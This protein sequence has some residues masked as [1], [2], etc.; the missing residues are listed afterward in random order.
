MGSVNRAIVFAS[1][2]HV[3]VWLVVPAQASAAPAAQDKATAQALFEEAR[4]LVTAGK[5]AEA[6]PK[7][8]E[9]DRL[10]PSQ[11]TVFRL[12]ECWERVGKFASA[13]ASYLEAAARAKASG[14]AARESFARGRADAVRD[15]LSFLVVEVEPQD[16]VVQVT[17]DGARVGAAQLGAQV[18]VDPGPHVVEATAPGYQP[19]RTTAVVEAGVAKVRVPRLLPIPSSTPVSDPAPARDGDT[20]WIGVGMTVAGGL[21]LGA[22]GLLAYSAKSKDDRAEGRCPGDVCDAEGLSLNRDART[23]GDVATITFVAGAA[24]TTAGVIV[25]L[26]SSPAAPRVGVSARGLVLSGTF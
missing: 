4:A 16:G 8:E 15:K 6:C 7:L 9:S 5:W 17:R 24:L 18:P 12:G 10:D 1:A 11:V 3:A 14:D 20:R 13:W 22:T 23:L 21:A 26:A 2:M 25:W 19:F